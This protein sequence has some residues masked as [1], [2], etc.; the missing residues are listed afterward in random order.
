MDEAFRTIC[1]LISPDL[2]FH[3]SSCKT[4]NEAWTTLEGIFGKQDEMRGHMLEVEFLTLDP[5]I[6]DNIQDFFT[7]FKDL[8]SQLKACGVDKSKEEK[9][10][11]LT[12]LSKLGPEFSVFVST[13][14]SVK[15]TSGATWKMPSLE[16]FIESLTQEQ[17]KLI[18]MGKIKGPK[19]H[20]LTVQDGSH[21]YQKS[22]DKDKRKSHA[23]PKKEGYSKPFTD[24]SG[25]KGGK[26]R[27][28][29]KCTYFHKGFHPESACMQ[30]QIDLMTQILQQNNLGDRIPEGAKKKKPEDQNPKKGN[31][32]HALIAINSSPDAWIVDSGASHHMAATKEVYS[33]L[34]AC[35]GPP[36]LMGDNSPVEVTDKGRIELTNGS[37]ENVL[38]VPKLSV[39]LL[40]VY[41][42]MNSGTGKKFIFTPN[43]V[44]IY[45]MQTNSRVAT[46]EVNHQSRLYTFSEFIE[47]D[48][49]LLLTHADESSR[50]WHERFRHLNFR[51]MQQ[52]SKKILVDG[53]PDIHFSKGV[54][55][56]CV[57]GKHPQE[58]FDKGKTQRASSPLDL[59]HSDLMGPFPHPSINKV[60]FVLIFV[61]DF[62]RFTWIYFLRKKSEVFQHLKDFKALV[63]TQSGK[64]IKVL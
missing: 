7:K 46:G 34:D 43:A 17:T 57:L 22:K 58:K 60:R 36:I 12:I 2:L 51:Y 59:I 49:A 56:G 33:S 19:A 3:I 39:N 16:D 25:S 1:S 24:A 10:M 52:L 4:P 13:F 45:D 47:P 53:L 32:S 21:Q 20:A 37:F 63:E 55:E 6:F 61:D 48:S 62:S 38:H 23:H 8:L 9:Q 5:K 28:G 11:V 64:K 29:E 54:C 30:K 40:S 41:Q 50:I 26:G 14:H 42:M 31:S 18:N 44:D 15:F 35:K 27:K